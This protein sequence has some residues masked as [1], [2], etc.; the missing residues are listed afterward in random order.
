MFSG[1]PIS[2]ESFS[3][4]N[5]A[6]VLPLTVGGT[7]HT[8]N[9]LFGFS[10]LANV[11]SSA[12]IGVVGS[13]RAN[14]STVTPSQSAGYLGISPAQTAGYTEK[15]PSQSAEWIEITPNP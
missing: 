10:V 12:L 13:V 7:A 6:V 1:F 11:T 8:G 3:A 9:I 4:G 5:P 2:E 15:T 14:W